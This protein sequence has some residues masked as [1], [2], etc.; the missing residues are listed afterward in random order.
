MMKHW[1]AISNATRRVPLS[2]MQPELA[3]RDIH[4]VT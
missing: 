3:K 2:L 4:I 1:I